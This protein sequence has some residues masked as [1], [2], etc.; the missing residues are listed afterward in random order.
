MISRIKGTL[1]ST[2]DDGRAM[3]QCGSITYEVLVPAADIHSLA[4]RGDEEVEF[5]TLHYLEAQGQGS[6]MLPKLIGFASERDRAFFLRF[7]TVKNI[8]Y[9]KALRA[10]QLPFHEVAAAIVA[11]DTARLVTLP[12]IGKRSAETII[13]E[14]NGKVDMFVDD[15]GSLG[16]MHHHAEASPLVA[17]T[18][19]M[20]MTLGESRQEARRLAELAVAA[21]PGIDAPEELLAAIYTMKE[22]VS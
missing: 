19:T 10:L 16:P 11:R 3:L 20:L 18:I 4:A 2:T 13:A 1:V 17:D 14:L 6:T 15:L 21:Q 7:T 8:G 22:A 9:R 5:H 12:E